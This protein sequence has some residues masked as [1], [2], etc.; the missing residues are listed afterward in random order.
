MVAGILAS[1]IA[2]GL[3]EIARRGL[4]FAREWRRDRRASVKLA[5]TWYAWWQ[6]RERSDP[7]WYR[8][9]LEIR[10]K[11][12][13][14]RRITFSNRPGAT[15][16]PDG[17]RWDWS[18]QGKVTAERHIVGSWK[19][20]RS[21]A[22]GAFVLTHFHGGF[23]GFIV[24]DNQRLAVMGSPFVLLPHGDTPPDRRAVDEILG[25]ARGSWPRFGSPA[26]DVRQ[27]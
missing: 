11:A 21:P 15:Q 16:P 9:E 7:I 24:G 25:H 4:I 27:V 8:D 23:N 22:R 1:L 14:A 17:Q 13:D 10:R 5:G 19:S 2:A 6:P 26:E 20:N 3:F 18:G 12:L